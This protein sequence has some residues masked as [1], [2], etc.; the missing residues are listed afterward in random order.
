MPDRRAAAE[1]AEAAIQGGYAIGETKAAAAKVIVCR[2]APR[3]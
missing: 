2:I 3:D 1:G